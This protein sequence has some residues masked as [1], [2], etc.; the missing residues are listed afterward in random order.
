MIISIGRHLLTYDNTI[1]YHTFNSRITFLYIDNTWRSRL[2]NIFQWRRWLIDFIFKIL[3]TGTAHINRWTSSHLL[4]SFPATHRMITINR[5]WHS[6]GNKT[7]MF[8]NTRK[9]N[10]T[11]TWISQSSLGLFDPVNKIKYFSE[12]KLMKPKQ[13]TSF[14][15]E[16]AWCFHVQSV[17]DKYLLRIII[18]LFG[19][20]F[21]LCGFFRFHQFCCYQQHKIRIG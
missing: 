12:E 21:V 18:H 16:H 20:W 4:L 6:T 1:E 19:R 7:S 8:V 11:E 9:K 14:A 13:T 5:E 17:R 15:I 10:D 3:N 2:T